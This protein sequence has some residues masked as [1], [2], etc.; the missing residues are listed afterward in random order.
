MVEIA[1]IVARHYSK[2]T[3]QFDLATLPTFG[4]RLPTVPR[5]FVSRVPLSKA[6]KARRVRM[7]IGVGK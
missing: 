6:A 3:Q 7:E 1:V 5:F 2:A 4:T